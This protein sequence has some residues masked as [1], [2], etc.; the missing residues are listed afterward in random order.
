MKQ[1]LTFEKDD[2]NFLDQNSYQQNVQEINYLT[3]MINSNMFL[4]KAELYYKK[5]MNLFFISNY[6]E[7]VQSFNKATD[8]DKNHAEAYFQKGEIF[9]NFLKDPKAA[10]NE[11]DEAIR[12]NPKYVE[13]YDCRGYALMDL[14]KYEDA[15]ESFDKIIR[16]NQENNRIWPKSIL[17]QLNFCDGYEGKALALTK[18]GRWEEVLEIYNHLIKQKPNYEHHHHNKAK[19][20]LSLNRIEEALDSINKALII[21]PDNPLFLF[22][23]GQAVALSR[24]R[25]AT[26]EFF[27]QSLQQKSKFFGSAY[28]YFQ[29][30]LAM[31]ILGDKV[32]AIR[33]FDLAIQN[34]PDYYQAYH[35][36]GLILISLGEKMKALDCFN[37]AIKINPD[38]IEAYY[39]KGL[40][41]SELGQQ[42]D[43]NESQ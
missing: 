30:G 20:L 21:Q 37:K 32:E 35:R 41:L 4:D 36:K 23:K 26:E 24:N 12:I 17:E 2:G 40:V 29:Q 7:A 6:E 5:G 31:N 18:L 15:V 1:N 9:R 39:A 28:T 16:I 11:L 3:Q 8:I 25:K 27:N 33:N 43:Q 10:V 34:S 22:T 14:H 42:S 19:A 13:A 38:Y